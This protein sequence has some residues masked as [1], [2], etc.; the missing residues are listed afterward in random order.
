MNHPKRVR[1]PSGPGSVR[2]R[3]DGN[4]KFV[5]VILILKL[6]VILLNLIQIVIIIELEPD[7]YTT[8]TTCT[9]ILLDKTSGCPQI[10]SA[11]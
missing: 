11:V 5:R 8:T 7:Y 4:L 2:N 9:I 3:H 6:I 10:F 1:C